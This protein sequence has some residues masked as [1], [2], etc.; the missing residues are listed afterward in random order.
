MVIGEHVIDLIP[1]YAL[2]CLDDVETI[3][4]L[5]H[6]NNCTSC[7]QEL[8]IY[9]RL[10]DQLPLALALSDPSPA[11]K[12][13]LMAEAGIRQPPRRQEKSQGWG[14]RLIPALRRSAPVWGLAGLAIVLML[15]ISNFLLWQRAGQYQQIQMPVIAL[16]GTEHAP[17]AAG[18]IVISRDGVEG[19]L[20]VDRLQPLGNQQQY[21]LWLI[22]DNIRTNGGVFSVNSGGYATLY[23]DASVPLTS[24]DGFGI[25]IEP[26]GGSPQPTGIKVLGG[27][28]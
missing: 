18:T 12:Q 27:S 14:D 9:Q 8:A 22:K 13:K 19:A 25:T 4:V 23:V 11:L 5:E 15:S 26:A 16:Q 1:A 20:V 21:Q 17:S 10:T 28:L 6:L 3:R 2:D 24:Y 7:R